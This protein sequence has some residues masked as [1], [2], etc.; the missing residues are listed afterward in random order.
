VNVVQDDLIDQIYEAAF[1][2]ELWPD[3]LGNLSAVSS[4]ADGM[5]LV[6]DD[7]RPI[8]VKTTDISGEVAETFFFA[9]DRWKE[10]ERIP[11]SQANPITG[12]VI[13]QDYYPPGF[14]DRDY[15]FLD[16]RKLGLESQIGTVIPMPSGELVAFVFN[17]WARNGSF[18][19]EDVRQLDL[20]YPHLARSGLMAARLGLERAQATVSALQAIEAARTNVEPLVRSIPVAA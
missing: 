8:G 16:L 2:P 20:L 11:Y 5:L 14:L 13:A 19:A 6:F 17:R 7:I 15:P 3:V 4:A 10:S 12:F 1:V 9:G 18:V